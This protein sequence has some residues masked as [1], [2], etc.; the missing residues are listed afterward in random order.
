MQ[1]RRPWG[2][3]L[4]FLVVS[5][6]M[7]SDLIRAAD[8]DIADC[9]YHLGLR[10]GYGH[11]VKSPSVWLYS[12]FPRW[13]MFLIHPHVSSLPGKLGISFE[14][15]GILSLAEAENTGWEIG[16]TPL[17]KFTLPLT[18][19]LHVFLEGGAGIIGEN[20]DSPAVPHAFN[21]TPQVGVGLDIALAP[22]LGVTAAYR[23]RHSSNAG[24]YEENPPFN[25][26]FFHAGLIYFY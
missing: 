15:E 22:R 5:T 11:H 6:I 9:H 4:A 8:F 7:C 19:G 21:F 20:F 3:T 23:F 1:A 25:V 17:L 16:V 24:L 10:F 13:G 12:L 14:V 26:H 18:R 2:F